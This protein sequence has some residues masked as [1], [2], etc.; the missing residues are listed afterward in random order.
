[1]FWYMRRF[2][3]LLAR[4]VRSMLLLLLNGLSRI[5]YYLLLSWMPGRL[6][7]RIPLPL[8]EL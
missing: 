4:Q 8:R 7:I 5:C 1:L 2:R 3:W 6:A